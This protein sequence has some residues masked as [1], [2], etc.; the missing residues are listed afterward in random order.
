MIAKVFGISGPKTFNVDIELPF[1]LMTKKLKNF[2][3]LKLLFEKVQPT[4]S[5][6]VIN[7]N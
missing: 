7:E 1:Y 4:K 5:V 3:R 6:L 2:C